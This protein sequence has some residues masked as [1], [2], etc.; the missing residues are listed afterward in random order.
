LF[1]I[2]KVNWLKL[3]KKIIA[4]HNENHT[5]PINTKCGVTDVKGAGTYSYHLALMAKEIM[6]RKKTK[7][8]RVRSHNIVSSGRLGG[9]LSNRGTQYYESDISSCVYFTRFQTY[10]NGTHKNSL[11]DNRSK[12]ISRGK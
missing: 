3:F 11:S 7:Y 9:G 2:T 1:P 6:C 10:R 8:S 5:E 12:F 4:V